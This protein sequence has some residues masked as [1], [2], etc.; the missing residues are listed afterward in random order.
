[1]DASKEMKLPEPPAEEQAD[2]EVG[3]AEETKTEEVKEE[4]K[5]FGVNLPVDQNHERQRQFFTER[6][7]DGMWK[8]KK[9]G[10]GNTP[11]VLSGRYTNLMQAEAA[12]NK[13]LE[14]EAA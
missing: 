2:K 6:T 13:F 3:E 10:G 5:S 1:M 9:Q 8:I 12:I 4:V 14:K 11:K 7:G